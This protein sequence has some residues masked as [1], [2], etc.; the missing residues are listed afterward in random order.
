MD[1]FISFIA[2][3]PLNWAPKYWAN[4]WGGKLTVSEN[5][6][7]FSL[8][9]ITYGGDGRINFNLPDFRGRVPLGYGQGRGLSPYQMGWFGG[10]E[11]VGLIQNQMPQHTHIAALTSLGIEFKASDVAG[12]ESTPGTNNAHT[13]AATKD[14]FNPG[15]TLY[16]SETPTVDL[17]GVSIKGGGV[18]VQDTGGSL[19][20]E[21]RQPYLVTNYIMSLQGI[22]PTRD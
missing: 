6:S 7:L 20:H 15:D 13:L 14:G 8:I 19:P 18:S 9:G 2:L 3:W 17:N 22:Y 4:C 11:Q 1:T 16:N 5:A 12:T 21:N 10:Y